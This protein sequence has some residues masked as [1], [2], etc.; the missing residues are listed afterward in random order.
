MRRKDQPGMALQ[1]ARARAN[2]VDY[3]QRFEFE[4]A[5]ESTP[6]HLKNV[7]VACELLL[8][9]LVR[10]Q[11]HETLESRAFEEKIARMDKQAKA[12]WEPAQPALVRA[13]PRLSLVP[14]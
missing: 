2:L 8:E 5:A 14:S 11:G 1:V 9:K 7:R 10:I 12:L 6:R 3:L 13:R 4:I